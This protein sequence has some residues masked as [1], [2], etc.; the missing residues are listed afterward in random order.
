MNK[1]FVLSASEFESIKEAESKVNGWWKSG[2]LKTHKVR[3]YKAVEVYD[4][5]MKFVK[6]K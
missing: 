5:E 2:D 3:L 4:L 1:Q 6:I